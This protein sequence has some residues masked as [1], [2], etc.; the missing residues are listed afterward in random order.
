[1]HYVKAKSILSARNGMNLYRGCQ[2]GCIYCDSRSHCYGMDHDF[3]DI[4]VK[5]NALILLE[6]ALRRRRRPCM[7]GTGSMS[8]PYM[9]LEKELGYTRRALELIRKYGFGATLITKSD[10]VLRD[11]DLLQAINEQ[12]K[13]VVQMTLTTCDERLCKVIEPGVCS[14]ARRVEVLKALRDA[15]IP[16]VVWLCPVLPFINDTAENIDGIISCCESAGVYGIINFGMGLTLRE[17][18]REYFY[19]ALDRHFP[20]LKEKYIRLYGM[21][22]EISS[23]R[24]QELMH[25]FHKRCEKAGIVHDN[26]KIFGYLN[27]FEKKDA[28]LSLF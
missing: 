7:I 28:Q 9:P 13:C 26:E 14:T 8:D 18:N 19:N 10:L 4:A 27:E 22:Y 6:D 11:I 12:T 21:A 17:G 25:L 20:G 3:E 24:N 5:E 16:T 23:P 2:H 15:G 1:M